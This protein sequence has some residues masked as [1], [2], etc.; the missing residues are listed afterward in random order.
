M[1]VQKRTEKKARGKQKNIDRE[2][3][4]LPDSKNT[5]TLS[6]TVPYVVIS[7]KLMCTCTHV[8]MRIGIC[9]GLADVK[10]RTSLDG[11]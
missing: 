7:A 5:R 9:I 4:K 11:G 6:T 8:H 3:K 2:N 10:L 1:K